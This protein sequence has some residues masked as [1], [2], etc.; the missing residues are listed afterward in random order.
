MVKALKL[1]CEHLDPETLG[2]EITHSSSRGREHELLVDDVVPP[3]RDD[4]EDSEET[5]AE[6]KTNEPANLLLGEAVHKF[7]AI[8]GRDSADSQ[9]TETTSSSSSTKKV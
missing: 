5:S 6:G 8:H 1:L 3:Q 9:D 2:D 4:E 7:Q